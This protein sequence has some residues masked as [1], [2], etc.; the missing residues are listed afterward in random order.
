M[1]EQFI[2]ENRLPQQFA[3]TASN[4]YLPLVEEIF[5][6]TQAKKKPVFIGINGCQGSGKST[7]VDF[8]ESVLRS[9]KGLDVLTMSLD[10]FY[11]P[12]DTRRQLAKDLHPLFMTRGVPGTHKI[13]VLTSII[14]QF[15]EPQLPMFIP[16]FNK[17]EDEPWHMDY[18]P[19][20]TEMP[21]VILIEGW[22]WGV[23]AQS[24]Q[25]LEH[26]I[27]TLE[28]EMD[29]KGI[30]RH[31]VNTQLRE[32]FEDAYTH[33]D[34]WVCLKAPSFDCVYQWRLEQEQKLAAKIAK[35]NSKKGKNSAIMNAKQVKHF[36]EY[37][38]RLTEHSFSTI[39]KTANA[40]LV[41][42]EQRNI[43]QVTYNNKAKE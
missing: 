34:Y 23:P 20:I 42:D 39:A 36:I 32:K 22:C 15:K 25:Q 6:L 26:P 5:A 38:R 14:S 10:D 21:D 1:F 17:A 9:Q 2:R 30:W 18:W 4:F 24:E 31:H 28:A 12:R 19:Y 33:M 11:Y 13:D 7:L 3:N 40:I 41:L 43:T 27:N 37:F 29:K 35:G 16:R 8:V